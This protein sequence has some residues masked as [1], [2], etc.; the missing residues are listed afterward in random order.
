MLVTVVVFVMLTV[1]TATDLARHKIYN[2][3]TY[4]GR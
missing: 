4:A 1:A 3:T 2:W